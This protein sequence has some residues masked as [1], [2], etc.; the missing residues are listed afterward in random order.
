[1]RVVEISD[2]GAASGVRQMFQ[3]GKCG[4]GTGEALPVPTFNFIKGKHPPGHEAHL[5]KE[6]YIQ[7]YCG[8]PGYPKFI[9]G[10]P[11]GTPRV[12]RE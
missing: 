8:Y 12:P 4:K 3:R 2:G 10:Y 11:Q 5:N 9:R 6:N 1:M 7:I